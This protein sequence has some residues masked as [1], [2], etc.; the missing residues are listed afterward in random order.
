VH[1]IFQAGQF[2]KTMPHVTTF[3]SVTWC[4]NP[5]DGTT[6]LSSSAIRTPDD[7]GV[8]TAYSI[9]LRARVVVPFPRLTY[10]L[11]ALVC[12]HHQT[13]RSMQR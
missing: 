12:C 7:N 1:P 8:C 10:T 9:E 3:C 2:P 6:S 11:S 4:N 5:L 13:M